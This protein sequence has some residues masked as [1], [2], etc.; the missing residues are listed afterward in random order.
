MLIARRTLSPLILALPVLAAV[1]AAIV[2]HGGGPAAP[3]PH[4]PE[5]AIPYADAAPRTLTTPQLVAR[6]RAE[7]AARP[8]SPQA[9]DNLALAELQMA[10]E[11]GDPTWYTHADA[12]FGHAVALSP[13]DFTAL[14]GQGSLALSRHDFHGALALGRRALS[15]DSASPFAMGVVVDAN[16]ELGRY[17]AARTAVERLL[18]QRPDLASYS[19]ASY[20][21][22]LHG[23]TA[24]ARRA[25]VQA[26]QSGAPVGENTAW[27]YLYL[28]NLDFNHGRY[29]EAAR[30]YRTALHAYPG[31][32]HAR[33]AQ[34]RLAAARGDY[35]A[36]IAGYKAV[37]G[38]YPLPAY[39]IALG[40]VYRA[41]GKPAAARRQ[42]ALVRA[43]E[44]LYAANGVNGD[45]ELA[46]FDDDH[47]GNVARALDRMRALVKIQPSVTVEDAL[48]WTLFRAGR[49]GAALAAST[50][51][52]RLGTR[53]SSFL[54]HRGAIEAR[55]GMTSAATRDLHA[56]L[57]L[58]PGFSL[59]YAPD[60]RR[61]LAR[62]GA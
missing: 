49:P 50:R 55:L 40:D 59:L 24:A 26:T 23:R 48:A 8:R 42:Y 7:A 44:R 31:F 25:L 38:R 32:L 41:A 12:L 29:A 30:S 28:G 46:L 36:A 61:L 15:I 21:L 57:R 11:D 62:M 52:L 20:Y 47:D 58:N 14:A 4:A 13:R 22:E 60:A 2:L 35:G 3:R 53:D 1:A 6:Y 17:G 56:A 16:V 51:A 5:A 9:A 33:A 34:A 37:V 18:D 54:Y 45:V 19:R 43:E 39:V 10:R 27:A